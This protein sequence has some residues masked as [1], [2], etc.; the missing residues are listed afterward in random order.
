MIYYYVVKTKLDNS[1]AQP[2]AI[3]LGQA[4]MNKIWK[5]FFDVG[6]LSSMNRV[7]DQIVIK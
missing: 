4:N 1:S 5:N 7:A 3:N 6:D 2:T